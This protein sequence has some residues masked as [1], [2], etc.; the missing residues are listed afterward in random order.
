MNEKIDQQWQD[1]LLRFDKIFNKIIAKQLA[2]DQENAYANK[3]QEH[4]KLQE[5]KMK[6]PFYQ[7]LKA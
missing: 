1:R 7:T 6:N 3:L 2:L 5:E 4:V